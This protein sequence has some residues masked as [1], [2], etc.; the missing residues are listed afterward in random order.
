MKTLVIIACAS[1][2]LSV[3][4]EPEWR[5]LDNGTVRIGIDRSRGACIGFFSESKTKRNLLNHFDEGRFVQQSYYGAK[6]GSDWNGKPWRYNPVQG[7]S[8]DGKAGRVLEY[9]KKRNALYAK[10]E[11][12]N[13][14]GG[15]PC[16]EAV[17][18]EWIKLDG[19]VAQIRFKLTYTGEDQGTPR[20][21]E[22]PA[23]FVDAVLSNL[24]YVAEGK[25]TRRCPDFPNEYGRAQDEWSAWL[26]DRDWGLGIDTPG[27][28]EFTCY[29]HK[30][31]GQTG[32]D[33]SAC[34]YISP[35]RTF[36]LTN[37]LEVEYEFYLTIGTLDEI[38]KRFEK[39]KNDH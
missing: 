10:I 31:N 16:P 24:V 20:H 33:G 37:G 22:M 2:F 17:M 25:L 36:A 29:R 4:G 38:R 12:R 15:E 9:D 1:A 19:P 6:D 11:P 30:G 35:L 23:V 34:S 18:E 32:P 7:G 5:F 21:Q 28:T 13:W 27:T 14:G 26:D 39:L 8:W 3:A